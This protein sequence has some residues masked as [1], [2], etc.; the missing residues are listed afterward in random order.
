MGFL[1]EGSVRFLLEKGVKFGIL[2]FRLVTYNTHYL[3]VI[4]F[5]S[6]SS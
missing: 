2:V 4:C 3:H 5:V 6:F 1:K